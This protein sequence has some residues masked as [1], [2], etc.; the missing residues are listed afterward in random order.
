MGCQ[1]VRMG[2]A[3]FT[4]TPITFERK[5]IFLLN[6]EHFC[7]RSFRLRGHSVKKEW[8]LATWCCYKKEK[9]IKTAVTSHSDWL[10]NWY[11]VP[12][13]KVQQGSMRTFAYLKK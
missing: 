1:N 8:S 10:G 6:L 2:G 12:V 3:T 4:K 13:S 9:Y 5:E 11:S 7:K